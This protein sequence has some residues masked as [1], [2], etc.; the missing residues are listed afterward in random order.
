MSRPDWTNRYVYTDGWEGRGEDSFGI[1]S[2][3]CQSVLRDMNITELFNIQ[4]AV[5]PLLCR[6]DDDS[7]SPYSCDVCIAAP[8]GEGKTLCFVLPIVQHL[9]LRVVPAIRC[10]VVLPTRE[11]AQ[12]VF[13]VFKHFTR[14]HDIHV[15]CLM[16]ES[17]LKQE[18]HRLRTSQPPD[19]L[20]C[21]PGRLVDHWEL[22][23]YQ[24]EE[25]G[26]LDLSGVKWIVLD[27]VDQLLMQASTSWLDAV[28]DIANNGCD[29]RGRVQ[30]ILCSATMTKNPQK[31]AKLQLFK[32]IFFLST[33]TGTYRAP[34][35]LSQK[36]IVCRNDTKAFVMVYLLF[37]LYAMGLR[38]VAV[39]VGTKDS[40]HRLC[41]LL[42]LIFSNAKLQAYPIR[43]LLSSYN[44]VEQPIYEGE[45]KEGSTLR[46]RVRELSSN[47]S[48]QERLSAVD[49]F[50]QGHVDVLVCSDV[51]ARGIDV[52]AVD[53]VVNYD[54]NI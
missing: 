11:L 33:K 30:K 7:N 18:S 35:T 20:V 13:E 28:T 2:E 17:S 15:V 52:K 19:V 44:P 49:K 26:G 48:L 25:G 34:D 29:G 8:T 4:R 53:A 14:Q 45:Y 41:R 32:P 37:Q 51:M 23:S 39:F 3:K 21:T 38:K 6:T 10:L 16:G 12:Q 47:F 24:Y 9:Y 1:L 46:L 40:T 27:E 54:S 50:R 31:L 5:L 36:Y 22:A 43:I 42:Q